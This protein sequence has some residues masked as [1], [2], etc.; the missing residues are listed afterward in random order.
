MNELFPHQAAGA[1]RI[2]DGRPTYLGLDMGIGKTRTFIEAVKTRDA[3]RVLVICPASAKLVWKR[4]I[5]LWDV[6]ATFAIVN[7]AKDLARPA[8]YY[9]V[10]HG[11]MSQANSEVVE[12]LAV[13]PPYD[14]AAID[15]AHAFNAADSNRVKALRRTAKNLGQIVPLS[16]TPMRNHAGDLYTLLSIC[17]PQCL[18]CPSGAVM[19]RFQFEDQFCKVQHKFFGG[20]R[21]IRVIEGSKNLDVL[22]TKIAPFMLRVRKEDVFKDLPPILWDQV[23]VPLDSTMMAPEDVLRLDMAVT[24]NMA[25]YG[26][27]A[28]L[29]TLAAGLASL[30]GDVGLMSL[31]RMLGAAKI[32]GA[33]EYIVD[34]LD[35]LPDDRKILVFAHHAHVIAALARHLG[36]YLPAVLTGTSTPKEREAAVDRFLTDKNCRVF[37]GNIQA[38]GT[39]ITLVGPTCKCS[40]VLFVESSWTPMDNAQAACRVR[41]IGQRDGVVARMLS[42]SGTI[43]DLINSLLV[44]KAREFTQL[45]DTKGETT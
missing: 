6:G 35:N 29:D 7:T 37:I 45:F 1:K 31:R 15:E 40:D 33:C 42:A 12:A 21:P 27:T 25:R 38:A 2:A 43:D 41:R 44:R 39:A 9:I 14:M 32:R 11:L 16:G 5:A 24:Q 8:K 4:E 30:G 36:E 10:S 23:P 28:P 26:A 20:S 17:F 19:S 13:W 3:K 18:K 34:M 22:K